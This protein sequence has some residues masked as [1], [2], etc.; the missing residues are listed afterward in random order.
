MET[1]LIQVFLEAVYET[2]KNKQT[3]MGEKKHK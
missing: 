3:E 2:K 1:E